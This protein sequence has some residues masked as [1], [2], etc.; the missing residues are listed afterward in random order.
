MLRDRSDEVSL[1]TARA[2]RARLAGLSRRRRIISRIATMRW[3]S[4][5]M[6]SVRQSPMPS[7][8]TR[9]AVWA[10]A[11][12]GVRPRF[13]LRTSSAHPITG[14][15]HPTSWGRAS[16][17]AH[18]HRPGDRRWLH[19]PGLA[20]W[21]R[22]SASSGRID[23]QRPASPR[24]RAFP[25]RVRRPPRGSS[26]RRAPSGCLRPHACRGCRVASTRTRITLRPAAL[27]CSASSEVSTISPAAAP[28]EA[29]SPVPINL[30]SALGSMVGM[31]KLVERQ[32]IDAP[33]GILA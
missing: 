18:Q 1:W 4:K 23:P 12:Y 8:P 7:A 19:V 10:S 29:G 31:E 11:E 32:G 33:H 30:R 25:Y 3:S 9:R 24:R 2:R 14:R 27:A 6:C 16:R 22:C 21:S 13:M 17:S 26:C 5:N 28:G 15:S 20:R